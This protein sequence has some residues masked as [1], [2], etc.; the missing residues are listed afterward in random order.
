[1]TLRFSPFWMVVFVLISGCRLP[2]RQYIERKTGLKICASANIQEDKSENSEGVSNFKL[3]M[4][5]D[6]YDNF[7]KSFN[8]PENSE[9]KSML[10]SGGKCMFFFKSK[11]IVVKKI[12]NVELVYIKMWS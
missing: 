6:C 11:S 5:A 10:H 9:C 1:M 4:N 3:S 8:S 7:L 12:E 2:D